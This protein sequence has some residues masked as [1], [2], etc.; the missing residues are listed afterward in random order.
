MPIFLGLNGPEAKAD[1]FNKLR[2]DC[3][4]GSKG[5]L[6][7][8][9]LLLAHIHKAAE[10]LPPPPSSKGT[11]PSKKTKKLA[12]MQYEVLVLYGYTPAAFGFGPAKPS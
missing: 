12:I 1:A 3:L 5:Q 7:F 4:P 10:Q 6:N 9:I 8:T 11:T 2:Q